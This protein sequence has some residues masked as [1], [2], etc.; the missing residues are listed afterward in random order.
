MDSRYFST[1]GIPLRTGRL[2]DQAELNRGAL[3]AVVNETFVKHYYP[4]GDVLGHSLKVPAIKAIL[5]RHWS[6]PAV[7]AGF[8]LSE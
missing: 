8:K 1:L 3:M 4:N 2:W 6:R 7:M 5:R